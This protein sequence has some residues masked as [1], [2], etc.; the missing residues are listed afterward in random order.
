MQNYEEIR[1]KMENRDLH[2]SRPL[3][4]MKAD[5]NKWGLRVI[6]NMAE[7]AREEIEDIIYNGESMTDDEIQKKIQET[8]YRNGYFYIKTSDLSNNPHETNHTYIKDQ[9]Q[10]LQK[11]TYEYEDNHRWGQFVLF[12]HV[13]LD[14]DFH[15]LKFESTRMMWH[16]LMTMSAG[17]RRFESNVARSLENEY[18]I[19]IYWMI[20][21]QEDER[22]FTIEEFKEVLGIRD[23]YSRTA[24]LI[25]K[26]LEPAKKELDEK[27]PYTFSYK[28][29]YTD[30]F[31]ERKKA[32]GITIYPVFQKDKR[33]AKLAAIDIKRRCTFSGISPEMKQILKNTYGFTT[34]EILNNQREIIIAEKNPTLIPL[35]RNR[36]SLFLTKENPKGY[37]ITI[38][39]TTADGIQDTKR[40]KQQ[41]SP[42]P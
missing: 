7:I 27:S 42:L 6:I 24:T 34:Q 1:K 20:T 15:M 8:A 22:P 23:K 2:I 10:K 31:A 33:D 17:W 21:E 36:S 32:T 30:P 3:A 35:L 25:K 41:G 29:H 19:R 18:A 5:I 13:E 14:K 9:L 4:F 11:L 12:S 28:V 16:A 38:I 39:K 40:I 26:V 37:V